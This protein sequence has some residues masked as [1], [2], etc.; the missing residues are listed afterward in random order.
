MESHDLDLAKS[1]AVG[2]R[3]RPTICFPFTGDIIGGSHY[4][5]RGLL[6]GLNPERYR[7][8]IV[9]QYPDGE[10][11]RFFAGFERIHDPALHWRDFPAGKH[12]GAGKFLSTLSHIP[13]IVRFLRRNRV[14]IV[15]SNDGRTHAGWGMAAR[16]AGAKLLWHHRG[17]PGAA[18]LNYLAPF[19]ANRILTV[20]D[21]ARPVH[22]VLPVGG[23]METVHSPFDTSIDVDR[24]AARN[25]LVRETGISPD[26]L[27]L[28]YFGIFIDRKRPLLFI[29]MIAEL[30]RIMPERPVYGMMF[31]K[32]D[33]DDMEDA[34]SARI[35]KHGLEN[36]IRLMGWR[37]PGAFWIASCDQLVIPAINEPFGRT[38]VEAMLVGT[39]I[40][41][42]RSGGNVEALLD[43]E[44]GM[45]VPPEN[46]RMLAEASTDLAN[47]PD[48]TEKMAQKAQET[49]R[50]RFGDRKH[51][52]LVSATYD[53]MLGL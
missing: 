5:V 22:P 51:C 16:L 12:I 1:L 37:S 15:H 44:V 41:A 10:I 38:L 9:P 11:A 28:G 24:V 3:H 52:E 6:E 20:S 19:I 7:T 53:R 50:I 46:A 2:K 29:D 30:R 36:H 32:A 17:D 43:G 23:R 49:A 27:I 4:S 18:G 25:T 14:D 39:P 31:G 13:A 8:I 42:T 45:L 26:A 47:H 35:A 33:G 48:R 40:V 21:F 34:I